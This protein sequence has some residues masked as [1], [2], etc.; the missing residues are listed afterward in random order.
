MQKYLNLA[1]KNLYRRKIRSMLTIG[2][3]G[4]A[5]A[6]LVS[7]LGFNSGYRIA[8]EKDVSGMGYQVLNR[9]SEIW[10]IRSTPLISWGKSGVSISRIRWEY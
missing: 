3:V 10:P 9:I 8:L 6:V 1:Y 5:V 2:G 4:V 7:L